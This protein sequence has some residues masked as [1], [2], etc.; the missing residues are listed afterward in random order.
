MLQRFTSPLDWPPQLS[1]TDFSEQ[2]SYLVGKIQS[3]AEGRKKFG[4]QS[5]NCATQPTFGV[6]WQTRL[7]LAEE[8]IRCWWH[9]N[10][11]ITRRIIINN[12]QDLIVAWCRASCS[13]GRL[14]RERER[15]NHKIILDYFVFFNGLMQPFIFFQILH[16]STST[17][18]LKQVRTIWNTRSWNSTQHHHNSPSSCLLTFL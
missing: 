16:S 15:E 1:T 8:W 13:N 17:E 10:P 5:N 4:E 3:G 2:F 18:L 14:Q 7:C 6:L 9:S 11:A 12:W